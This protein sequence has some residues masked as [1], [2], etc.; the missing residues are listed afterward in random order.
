MT[1]KLPT[2]PLAKFAYVQGFEGKR[3]RRIV[4]Y[5]NV[6]EDL[7]TASLSK[8]PAEVEL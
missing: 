7:G 8:L 5:Y 1:P 2:R 4:A 6:C 3:G